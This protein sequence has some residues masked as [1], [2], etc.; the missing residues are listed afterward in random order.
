MIRI[1]NRN[2]LSIE[3]YSKDKVKSKQNYLNDKPN[4][5]FEIY[6]ENGKLCQKGIVDSFGVLNSVSYYNQQGQKMYGNTIDETHKHLTSSWVSTYPKNLQ[7]TGYTYTRAGVFYTNNVDRQYTLLG[8][9]FQLYNDYTYSKFNKVKFDDGSIG[10]IDNGHGSYYISH[11]SENDRRLPNMY[12]SFNDMKFYISDLQKNSLKFFEIP[13][14]VY[15]KSDI[16]Y[17]RP[18]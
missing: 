1:N 2:G 12:V 16:N 17:N 7:T 6:F 18:K 3:Y 11:D 13:D 14:L 9:G 5:S 15:I 8:D 10:Y 4:G